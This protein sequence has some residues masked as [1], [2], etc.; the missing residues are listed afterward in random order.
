M[1]AADRPSVTDDARA[2]AERHYPALNADDEALTYPRSAVREHAR[3]GF[4]K[5]YEAGWA[6]GRAEATTE[7]TE[8]IARQIA[9]TTA[10]TGLNARE[11]VNAARAIQRAETTTATTEDAARVLYESGTGFKLTKGKP[12]EEL[13]ESSRDSQRRLAQALADAGLL[14][15]ARTRALL[16][17][18]DAQVL[19]ALNAMHPRAAAPS[20]DYWGGKAD[21]MRTALRAAWTEADR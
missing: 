20:L 8:R 19:A 1:T 11:Y 9:A 3:G 4:V 2:E 21:E 14:A 10:M 15:T 7:A 18:T 12:W 6:A 16:V 5:G 13:S 17:P